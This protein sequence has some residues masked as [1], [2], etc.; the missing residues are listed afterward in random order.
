MSSNPTQHTGWGN[1]NPS[2]G[3]NTITGNPG[4]Y[5]SAQIVATATTSS[6]TGY[7]AFLIGASADSATTKIFTAGGAT[8]AGAEFGPD[9][10]YEIGVDKVQSTG[11]NVYI[12]KSK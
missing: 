8:I 7:S 5:H 9:I 12:F 1:I 4:L 2:T 11:G 3:S 10:L 6:G